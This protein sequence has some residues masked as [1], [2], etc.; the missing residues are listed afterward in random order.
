MAKAEKTKYSYVE[1]RARVC[2][3]RTVVKGTWIPVRLIFQR[4]RG[5]Q[6]PEEIQA[7]YPHH[8]SLK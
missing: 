8:P 4:Y 5:G 3:G 2:G 1:K 7:A 6:S